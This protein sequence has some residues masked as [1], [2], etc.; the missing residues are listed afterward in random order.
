VQT[1]ALTR[2]A[3]RALLAPRAHDA[4][5]VEYAVAVDRYLTG[6]PLGPGSRR[7]YR[8]SLTSWAWPLVGKRSPQ[9]A[10]RRG[11]APPVVPLALLDDPAAAD[12]LAAA[13]A[14]RAAVTDARTVN[15]ELS[16]LRSA[17]GWWERQWIRADPTAGLQHLAGT[18]TMLPALSS[19]QVASLFRAPAGLREQAFWRVLHDSAARP[20]EVLALDAV[21]LDLASHRGRIKAPWGPGRP[22]MRLPGS[23][24]GATPPTC[25]AG[26]WRAGRTGRSS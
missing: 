21:R 18:T 6:A 9:G 3:P 24:G 19:S 11:A 10:L 22:G 4:L 7:I 15:R 17:V 14:D 5:P 25:S 13:I 26:C 20:E 8:I 2:L 16:A 12:R 23:S 1:D